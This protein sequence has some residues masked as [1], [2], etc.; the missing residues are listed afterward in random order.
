MRVPQKSLDT[1]RRPGEQVVNTMS[2]QPGERRVP[3]AHRRAAV[4]VFDLDSAPAL[5][6]VR[7]LGR[8]GVFVTAYAAPN[9]PK[10]AGRSRWCGALEACPP[11]EDGR[12]TEWLRGQLQSGAITH[13]APTSDGI[14]WVCAELR[15]EFDPIVRRSIAPLADLITCLDKARFAEACQ[16]LGLET[17]T[18][19]RPTSLDE[20][21]ADAAALGY[22]VVI[23]PRSHIGVGVAERGGVIEN[24]AQ[25]LASFKRYRL[26][27]AD[28]RLG[29]LIPQLELPLLQ[30]FIPSVRQQAYCV[31]G[32]RDADLGVTGCLSSVRTMVWPP[33]V[34]ISAHQTTVDM[35]ALKRLAK[36]LVDAILPVGM[37]GLELLRRGDRYCAIDLNPRGFGFMALN[38]AAGHDLAWAWYR[39]A[40]GESITLEKPTAEVHRWRDPVPFHLLHWGAL[41]GGPHRARELLAYRDA[42]A[43]PS[44][45]A[46]GSW[47]DPL[48]KLLATLRHLRH[49]RYVLRSLGKEIRNRQAA[50]LAPE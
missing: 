50:S 32:F 42:L 27:G 20:A 12:F 7:S 11:R 14:A 41:I 48:P 4:A 15:D 16:R 28:P 18:I 36:T 45:S 26:A 23:K 5:E 21:V 39:A 37:F 46:S 43:H 38:A 1:E 9:A 10:G 49:P 22:P 44:A 33:E 31:T 8:R 17:P 30:E 19:K 24:E 35:P 2:I 25:L 29:D 40:C 6:F 3:E 13:V 47:S 34:G